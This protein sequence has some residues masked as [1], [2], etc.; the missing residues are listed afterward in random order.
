MSGYLRAEGL[1]THL[2]PALV[3]TTQTRS[4]SVLLPHSLE[5]NSP[6]QT[7]KETGSW[8]QGHL[9]VLVD[10]NVGAGASD[11]TKLLTFFET[12]TATETDRPAWSL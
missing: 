1:P 4:L 11:A 10:T 3:E 9:E 2:A 8:L 7:T 12:N 5:R 6:D